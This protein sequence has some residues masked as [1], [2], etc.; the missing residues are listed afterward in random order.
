LDRPL[1]VLITD[2]LLRNGT[3]IQGQPIWVCLGLYVKER[4]GGIFRRSLYDGDVRR[5]VQWLDATGATLYDIVII[6]AK[7]G[8]PKTAATLFRVLWDVRYGQL[9]REL[10]IDR[11]EIQIGHRVISPSTPRYVRGGGDAAQ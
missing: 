9:P 11:E 8:L 2:A 1:A 4:C 3:E 6:L 7:H 5:F 10:F